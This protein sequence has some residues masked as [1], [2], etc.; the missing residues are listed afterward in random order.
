MSMAF[1]WKRDMGET[2]EGEM[3]ER[4]E[5]CGR[6]YKICICNVLKKGLNFVR[7]WVKIDGGGGELQ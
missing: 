1:D 7:G 4:L 3:G 6:H 5:R 2:R